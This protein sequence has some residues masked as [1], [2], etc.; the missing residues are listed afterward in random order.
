MALGSRVLGRWWGLN[1]FMG[2]EPPLSFFTLSFESQETQSYVPES[3]STLQ[4][5]LWLLL[6]SPCPSL[7]APHPGCTRFDYSVV[8]AHVFRS[9]I[10]CS[11]PGSSVHGILQSRILEWVAMPPL[12]GI[13]PTQGSNLHIW[14]LLH[15]QVGS[16]PL[17]SP[18]KSRSPFRWVLLEIPRPLDCTMPHI[19]GLFH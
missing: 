1:E 14:C 15:W 3:A 6:A 17:A 8:L 19:L 9:P 18:G 16:L 4:I 13:F 5:G 7:P 11:L 10:D 2:V 12:Q